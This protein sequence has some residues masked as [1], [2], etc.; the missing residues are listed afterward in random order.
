MSK[1]VIITI[2]VL[3]VTACALFSAL[4][5]IGGVA[6]LRAQKNYTQPTSVV[7]VPQVQ[8]TKAATSTGATDTPEGESSLSPEVLAQMDEIQSQV[9]EI[10]GLP[11]KTDLIRDLMTPAELEDKVVNDFF[12]DY[13]EEDAASDTEILSRL[14]LLKSD[15][16]LLQFYLDLY[17]EQIAGFYDSETKEMYV[18][19]GE[20]FGGTE[21]RTYAHEFNHA[22]QDQHYDLE[23]GMKLNDDYC[24]TDTEY[25]AAVSALIEGDS[26][27]TETYW[28]YQYAT[29]QDRQDVFDFQSDYSSPVYDSAPAYMK[30][31]FLFP[32]VKGQ[33]FVQSLIDA[34][35]WDAVDAAYANPP[36]TTEQ[37]LHP[38]KY[39]DNKPV[40]VDMPDL[41]AGLDGSWEELDRNVMGE[42]YTHLILARGW[43][44]QFNMDD[45]ESQKAAAGW[46]GDTY[47]YYGSTDSTGYLFAWRSTWEGKTDTNEY[48]DLSRKYGLARWGIPDVNNTN[49]V[50]WTSATDGKVT[51]RRSGSDVL[52][53][54]GSS[55]DLVDHAL[56]VI[57]DF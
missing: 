36:V 23:N 40:V 43:N 56:E 47:V 27:N 3:V 10:R 11:Q 13:T 24:E 39:P 1:K 21:R 50:S 12:K 7:V 46:D 37:I 16:N 42:W 49:V 48:F 2:V 22:L 6:L 20:N 51:L 29:D 30:E 52:W 25:C 19:G 31:D 5:I 8:P 54:M 28:F 57:G 44:P 38:E 35:G 18:I 45:A 41:T 33:V 14:G 4:L 9:S 34:G 15:F 32:Y 55:Q 53:V 26:T 17:S